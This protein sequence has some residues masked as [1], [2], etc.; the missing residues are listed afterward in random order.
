MGLYVIV[1]CFSLSCGI[2]PIDV[3][4]G[5]QLWISTLEVSKSR[6]SCFSVDYQQVPILTGIPREIHKGEFRSCVCTSID[7]IK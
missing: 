1:R 2:G 3:S 7:F 4:L 5:M 6:D